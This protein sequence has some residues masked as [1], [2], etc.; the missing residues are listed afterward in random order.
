M[1]KD[2]FHFNRVEGAYAGLGG[3]LRGV[4]PNTDFR[5]KSG[6]AFDGEFWQHAYGVTYHIPGRARV[7]ANVEWHDEVG[8]RPAVVLSK[9]V[10]STVPALFSKED[11]LDY[12][13]E[14]GFSL[15]YSTKIGR[16]TRLGVT[17]TD[18]RQHSLSVA[19][20]YSIFDTE[21]DRARR[22]PAIVDGKLRSVGAE[23]NY[24]SR[25]LYRS[26]SRVDTLADQTHTHIEAGAEYASPSFI[27]TDFDFRRYYVSLYTRQRLLGLGLFSIHAVWGGSDRALPPQRYFTLSTD[28]WA[29]F[30]SRGFQTLDTVNFSGSRVLKITAQQD[31]GR[32]LFGKSGLPLVKKIPFTVA[33]HGGVFWADFIGHSY[34]P[35]DDSAATAHHAYSE[36]GFS[37]GNLTPFL[38]PFN[39]R[40]GFTWQLSDYPTNRFALS[41]DFAM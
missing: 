2:L 41:W 9:N 37:L 14:K 8:H 40:L 5:L 34:Q 15:G 16:K 17:Y 22:N 27:K 19:T 38:A 4:L 32:R 39:L 31:F 3:R 6:Y 12:Y 7:E 21:S 28:P 29:M 23:F 25:S 24:D 33:V 18:V 13:S 35:G 30:N 26:K 20:D 11:P 10:N 1:Q 36:L